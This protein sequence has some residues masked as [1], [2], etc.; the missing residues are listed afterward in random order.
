[1]NGRKRGS[2][3]ELVGTPDSQLRTLLAKHKLE[4]EGTI[5]KD[6]LE[7]KHRRLMHTSQPRRAVLGFAGE[8]QQLQQK[9]RRI[10]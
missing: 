10:R 4:M 2:W 9:R 6:V 8:T 1:M 3:V 5:T 7:L